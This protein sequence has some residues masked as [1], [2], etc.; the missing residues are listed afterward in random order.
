M[1]ESSATV[2]MAYLPSGICIIL[3]AIHCKGCDSRV[4]NKL[5]SRNMGTN[6]RGCKQGG[7]FILVGSANVKMDENYAAISMTYLPN[8]I[9]IILNAIRCKGYDNRVGNKVIAA[10]YE[11]KL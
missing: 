3:N 2:S 10:E 9:S 6:F 4:G 11:N 7:E 1:D 5:C 8:D